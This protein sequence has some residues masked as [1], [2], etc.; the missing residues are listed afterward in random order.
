MRTQSAIQ[1][2]KAVVSRLGLSEHCSYVDCAA[3][4]IKAER[5]YVTT[6]PKSTADAC[7]FLATYKL[8]MLNRAGGPKGL[9]QRSFEALVAEK[10]N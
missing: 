8:L 5:L 2:R 1:G 9:D 6:V 10:L 3:A 7:A 4:I